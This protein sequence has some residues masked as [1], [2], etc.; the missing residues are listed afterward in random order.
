MDWGSDRY[1]VRFG[2]V[3]A[4]L[5][6]LCVHTYMIEFAFCLAIADSGVDDVRPVIQ[7][8]KDQGGTDFLETFKIN[9][10]RLQAEEEQRIAEL[11]ARQNKSQFGG[12]NTF[13][14]RSGNTDNVRECKQVSFNFTSLVMLPYTEFLLTVVF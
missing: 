14:G 4:Q 12:F 3:F 11:Q 1:I 8:Y 9:Q 5:S 7:F 10:A 2:K 6:D 13:R